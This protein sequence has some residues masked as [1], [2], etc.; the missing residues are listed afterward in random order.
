MTWTISYVG[1][2]FVY[3]VYILSCFVCQG[4]DGVGCDI[5]LTCI[6][7]SPVWPRQLAVPP[8]SPPLPS[9]ESILEFASL[10]FTNFAYMI[11]GHDV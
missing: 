2:L 8:S 7:P 4:W 11:D 1:D 6:S 9:Y 10:V 5:S 3:I